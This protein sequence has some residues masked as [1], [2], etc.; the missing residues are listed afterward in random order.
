[1]RKLLLTTTTLVAFA[2]V[3]S[4]GAADLPV[5]APPMVATP[6]AYNWTGIYFGGNFGGGWSEL[7][8]S[9]VTEFP[10]T[11]SFP[12]GTQF[13]RRNGSGPLGGVQGGFNWQFNNFVIGVEG[14]YTWSNITGSE[15]TRS[16]VNPAITETTTGT[17]TDIALATGRLGYAWNNWLL[18]IKG[19]GAW[20]RGHSSSNTFNG[21]GVIVD[22]TAS[23]AT[24]SGW[25]IGGGVE[26]GFWNNWSAKI[27]YNHIDF[28][29]E[30]TTSVGTFGPITGTTALRNSS[31]TIDIV[32][33]G[34]NYRFNWGYSP[35]VARY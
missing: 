11:T 3:G 7:D 24:R 33:F 18:Y 29:S 31:E 21:A 35:V 22:S 26:W 20:S 17:V 19:G 28:G 16:L 12:P 6:V 25:T 1:M 9:A 30:Q 34:L 8:V 23:S 2:A 27:E 13:T 32:K 15:T 14:D 5:K 4:A 10:G